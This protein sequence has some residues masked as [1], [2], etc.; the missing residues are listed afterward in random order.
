MSWARC[1]V[2]LFISFS[3]A[4]LVSPLEARGEAASSASAKFSKTPS[5]PGIGSPASASRSATR[6]SQPPRRSPGELQHFLRLRDLIVRVHAGQSRR[7]CRRSGTLPAYPVDPGRTPSLSLAT[8]SLVV[9]FLRLA[10][11]ERLSPSPEPSVSRPPP[12]PRS[13]F[14]WSACCVERVNVEG[15]PAIGNDARSPARRAVWSRVLRLEDRASC[16]PSCRPPN[17]S[18]IAVASEGTAW[19]KS[20]T[21]ARS[22]AGRSVLDP[23]PLRRP[24]REAQII[25]GGW[26]SDHAG[27]EDGHVAE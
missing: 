19:S 16:V 17:S 4:P 3:I 20:S 23:R 9:G 8:A 13:R 18:P 21:S 14:A 5:G 22:R 10:E 1:P 15:N 24:T 11:S 7:S 6:G 12:P 27:R 26:S 25:E 2:V